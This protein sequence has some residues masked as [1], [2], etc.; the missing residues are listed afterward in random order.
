MST[1]VLLEIG[2]E[3]YLEGQPLKDA[4]NSGV[5]RAYADGYFRKNEKQSHIGGFALSLAAVLYVVVGLLVGIIVL[6]FGIE[7]CKI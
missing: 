1:L 5:R 7:D 2:Q 6:I 3:V 4:V